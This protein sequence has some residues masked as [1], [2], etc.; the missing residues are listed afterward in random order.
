MSERMEKVVEGAATAGCLGASIIW[1][2]CGCVVTIG[3]FV[4]GFM[5]LA[6]LMNACVG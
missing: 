1:Q 5:F 4:I 3:A 2:L 6:G